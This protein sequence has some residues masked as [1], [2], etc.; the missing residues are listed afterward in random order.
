MAAALYSDGF[1]IDWVSAIADQ[2][3][4]RRGGIRCALGVAAEIVV[5]VEH[6]DRAVFGPTA[7]RKK[8]AA[9]RPLMRP[10]HDDEVVDRVGVVGRVVPGLA[11]AQRM[12]DFPRAIVAAAHSGAR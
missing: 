7:L 8:Y 10:A 5:I 11:V 2:G 9:A 6:E 12:R 3:A 1:S 4:D